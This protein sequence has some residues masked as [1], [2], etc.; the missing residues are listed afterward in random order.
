VRWYPSSGSLSHFF[1]DELVPASRGVHPRMLRK[2]E[3]YPTNELAPYKSGF[4]SGW[5]VERYQIDLV[6]AAQHARQQMDAQLRS[7]C[8]GKVPGD[9]HR[10][11]QVY[12]NYSGQTFKHIL[13]PLWLLTYAFG[14]KVYQVVINGYTGA[15]A[16]E[17]PKSWVK[18]TIAILLALAAAGV[19]AWLTQ[20]R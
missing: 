1:N 2:V 8:A 10:N 18:I 17:Y 14:R 4:L 20:H 12:P 9:T 16:G 11:L 6:A 13:V 19:V 15:I 3:P 5:V 7:M